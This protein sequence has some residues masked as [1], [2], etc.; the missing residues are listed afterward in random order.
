M[1]I[2]FLTREIKISKPAKGSFSYCLFITIFDHIE[3]PQCDPERPGLAGRLSC[4]WQWQQQL[5]QH[6]IQTDAHDFSTTALVA[7]PDLTAKESI[8]HP[9]SRKKFK[10]IT[11]K[12]LDIHNISLISQ[13]CSSLLVKSLL[14]G[15]HRHR[16][17]R[18]NIESVA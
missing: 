2:S 18:R 8:P 4:V 17:Q 11:P 15:R 3:L 14:P 9:E 1:A 13:V 10:G 12:F 16:H 5:M 6:Q 7:A